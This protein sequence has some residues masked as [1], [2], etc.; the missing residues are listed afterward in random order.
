MSDAPK[1]DKGHQHG[2]SPSALLQSWVTSD[3]GDSR[4]H[5]VYRA[6]SWPNTLLGRAAA[7]ATT[8]GSF[9][10]AVKCRGLCAGSY[11][12]TQFCTK[13]ARRSHSLGRSRQDVGRSRPIADRRMVN[14]HGI[15]VFLM[16]TARQKI[17]PIVLI[18]ALNCGCVANKANSGK[19]E[20][21]WVRT[22]GRR[23]VDD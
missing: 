7:K 5:L 3:T 9:C 16:M 17:L 2:R 23:I 12:G 10:L 11:C 20:M 21:A 14:R 13:E 4:L 1:T 8:C 22:D 19:F 18:A 6:I 15:I